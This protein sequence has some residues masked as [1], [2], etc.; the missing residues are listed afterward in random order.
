MTREKLFEIYEKERDYQKRVF[1]DPSKSPCLNIASFLKFIEHYIEKAGQ[2]YVDKWEFKKPAWFKGS[3]EYDLQGSAPIRTYEHL[4][5]IMALAGAALEVFA[6]ID[7]DFWREE[8]I[9]TKWLDS[10]S[11]R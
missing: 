10:R 4:I 6:E 9:K 11:D 8:G 5:K 2:D 7:P 1:G 3:M